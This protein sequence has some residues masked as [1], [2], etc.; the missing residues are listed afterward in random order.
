MNRE[1]VYVGSILDIVARGKR[2]KVKVL[3][4]N[5]KN[6]KCITEDGSKWN[7]HPSFLHLPTDATW[8]PAVAAPSTPGIN[9]GVVVRFKNKAL[10]K[11]PLYVVI[12]SHASAWRVAALGGDGGRYYRGISSAELEVVNVNL[13]LTGV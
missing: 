13:D 7:A 5:P 10:N 4:V 9:L 8:T 6:I 3:K 11:H 12:G 1:D 2:T